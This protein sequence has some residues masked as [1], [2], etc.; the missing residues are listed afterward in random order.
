MAK[1]FYDIL[2]VSKGASEDEIKK[3]YRKL[4][5]KYHPDKGGGDEA[6]FKEISEAYRVLSDKD[7]RKQYDQFGQTF[8]G[9]G[10]FGGAQGFGGFDFSGFGGRQGGFDF[11]GGGFEDIFSEMFGGASR[12][13]GRSGSRT[14]SDIQVD[15]EITFEEMAKGVKKNISLRRFVACDVCH[16]SGGEPG[17]SEETCPTCQGKGRV[18][19]TVKSFLGVFSQTETCSTCQGRGKT[20][21]KKCHKCHGDGRMRQDQTISVDIPAGIQNGQAISL[22]GQGE[23]GEFGGRSGDLFVVVH[24][25][26][27]ARFDRKGDDV[28]STVSVSFS[29]AV[30]GEKIVV[31]TLDG[32]VKMT[33]PS[34][35]QSGE[36]FRIREKGV[37]H[38]QRRGRGDH[39]VK[40]VVNIPK[41]LSKEQKRLIEDL[42][43]LDG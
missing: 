31:E 11:S 25:K 9:S 22:S 42:G 7:K 2:G 40:V 39:L 28:F 21:S 13:G 26:P 24:V 32:D 4:A 36:V 27:H 1:D 17:A 19:R 10:G 43:K 16:G 35:T 3:A 41:K 6:K 33:V 18:Q 8:D 14:G 37:P 12:G 34:G 23:A 30:L 20:F 15:V 29:Q 38:L 5:H